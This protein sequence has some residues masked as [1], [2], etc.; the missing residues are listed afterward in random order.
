MQKNPAS[1]VAHNEAARL[2]V[3]RGDFVTAVKEMQVALSLSP[4]SL[5]AQHVDLVRRLQ[6]HE[7]INK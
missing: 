4:E 5:K 7:D 1:W 2:A 6:D 3:A